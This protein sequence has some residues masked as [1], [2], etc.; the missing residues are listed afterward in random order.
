MTCQA[1]TQKVTAN[2]FNYKTNI[3]KKFSCTLF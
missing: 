1:V 2:L 3:L